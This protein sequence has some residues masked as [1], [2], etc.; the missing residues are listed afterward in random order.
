MPDI[1]SLAMLLSIYRATNDDFV[2]SEGGMKCYDYVKFPKED[3]Y[4]GI[5][6]VG[7]YKARAK[8]N[9]DWNGQRIEI[10]LRTQ[11]QHA[12]STAVETVTAFTRTPLK[13]G[14]GPA[15]W[16]RFFSLVGSLFAVQEGTP[17]VPGTPSDQ[18]ELKI[19][20]RRLMAS[21]KV[22]KRLRGWTKALSVLPRKEMADARWILLVLDVAADT[23]QTT[24]FIDV[25]MAVRS[26]SAIETS[27]EASHLDAVLVSVNSIH[28]LRSAYPNY[29]ADTRAFIAAL[30]KALRVGEKKN[31]KKRR[32]RK[33]K[34]E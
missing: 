30:N 18:A 17:Q 31:K 5:H 13:F 11:L 20:L 7:R 24:G 1:Q 23:I 33:Q 15:E 19:E 14:G 2:Q 28:S 10:Q 29:Y 22:R 6:L 3:G 4:R 16:R 21:L 25:R 32:R 27:P 34:S 26:V 12:F 9:E 8:K